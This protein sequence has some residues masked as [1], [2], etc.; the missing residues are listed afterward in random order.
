METGTAYSYLINSIEN[1]KYYDILSISTDFIL[2][3]SQKQKE[4]IYNEIRESKFTNKYKK[5][6]QTE[7]QFHAYV[8]E[9][10]GT[11]S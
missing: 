8:Y 1:L 3:L 4:L 10:H 5:A 6:P 7:A 2:R 9:K 11:S